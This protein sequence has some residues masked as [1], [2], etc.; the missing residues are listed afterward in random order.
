M[1]E[2]RKSRHI[3]R[4]PL[5]LARPIQKGL[6]ETLEF[7]RSSLRLFQTLCV[8]DLLDEMLSLLTGRTLG[9][10]V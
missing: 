2:E 4:Q 8:K 5:R 7:R 1:D 10:P 9:I 6:A 3:E